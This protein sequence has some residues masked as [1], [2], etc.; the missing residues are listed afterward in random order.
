[1]QNHNYNFSCTACGGCCTQ[2][3]SMS[4]YDMIELSNEFIF[5]VSHHAV[6]S[7]EKKPL[8][9]ALMDHYQTLGHTLVL[10]EFDSVLFYWIDF[11]AMNA[12]SYKWCSKLV[13]SKCSIYS[14]RPT[15]CKLQPLDYK[16][17]E[18]LQYKT[19]EFYK[20]KTLKKQW[21][22]NFTETA[23]VILKE[24]NISSTH[25]NSL[26][27]N[28]LQSIKDF[29]DKYI[30]SME[31]YG[32]RQQEHFKTVFKAH[33]SKSILVTDI[34][35]PLFVA[36]N[37]NMISSEEANDII[38][39]QLYL[40]EKEVERA[41]NLKNKED[42]KYSRLYKKIIETYEKALQNKIFDNNTEYNLTD[43]I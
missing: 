25:L 43:A 3:P 24:D 20:E 31:I 22:C 41:I 11:S 16:L 21:A 12:P 32:D 34:I 29:T 37:H 18:Q 33:L 28:N 17:P 15:S 39:N 2:S 8:E 7:Q 9:K 5:Q 14:K 36:I 26:Y 1:M 23:P 40:I 42:V 35:Q 6:V 13:D 10:P 30:D 38:K 4:I 19:I 27:Y